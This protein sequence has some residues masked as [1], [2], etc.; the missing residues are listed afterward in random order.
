MIFAEIAASG[1]AKPGLFGGHIPVTMLAADAE[2]LSLGVNGL[3]KLN[4]F[5]HTAWIT[6]THVDLLICVIVICILALIANRVIKHADPDKVPG[7]FQNIIEMIVEAFDRMTRNTMGEKHGWKFANYIATLFTYLI[8]VNLSGL[9]G[10]RAPTADYGMPL[11]LALITFCIIHYN[12]FKY[13]K[14]GH[15]TKLFQ[16]PLLTPINIIGEVATPLSMSLRLFGNVMSGTI[17]LGLLYGLL[18]KILK[19]CIFPAF[20]ALHGYFDVFSGCIQAYVFCMLTMTFTAQCFG[21]E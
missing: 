11:G 18:P 7:T 6:T 10:L 21:D 4:I 19:V 14:V 13:E 1:F 17:M 2:D 9:F 16:P 8:I 5:G 20:S 15:V 3:V 12:G